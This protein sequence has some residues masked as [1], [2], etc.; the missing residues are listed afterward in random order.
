ML[1]QKPPL[2]L[3]NRLRQACHLKRFF[4]CWMADPHFR[5]EFAADPIAAKTTGTSS[6]K[7]FARSGNGLPL[8]RLVRSEMELT[9]R[10][11]PQLRFWNSGL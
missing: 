10:Q 11:G 5:Q 4:E 3:K 8:H 7:C 6:R 1:L 9:L 2:S